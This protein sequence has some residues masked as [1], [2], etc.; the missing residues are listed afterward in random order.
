MINPGDPV[1][2]AKDLEGIVVKVV[3]KMVV[4]RYPDKSEAMVNQKLVRK[5]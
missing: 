2:V 1:I 5:G 3:G 4:V